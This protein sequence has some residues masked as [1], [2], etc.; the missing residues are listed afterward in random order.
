[1]GTLSP[2][3]RIREEVVEAEIKRLSKNWQVGKPVG[4]D[5][6]LGEWFSQDE[7]AEIDLFDQ[8]QLQMILPICQQ[9]RSLSEAG[10]VL[11]QASRERKKQ[12]NDADRL[13]KYLAKFNL[14]WQMVQSV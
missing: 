11:Y 7:L 8:L 4:E 3:G 9:S 12:S 14:T 13:K 1:M 5:C 6:D 2:K 10:R